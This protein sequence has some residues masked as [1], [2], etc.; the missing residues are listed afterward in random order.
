MNLLC[1]EIVEMSDFHSRLSS[2]FFCLSF[3]SFQQK[4]FPRCR[5]FLCFALETFSF[6]LNSLPLSS[7]LFLFS[8]EKSFI[9]M[10][11]LRIMTKMYFFTICFNLNFTLSRLFKLCCVFPR[12]RWCRV[13]FRW[14]EAYK[15]RSWFFLIFH[16]C[17]GSF[18]N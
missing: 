15:Q 12:K 14:D 13:T 17:Y 1:A 10:M 4:T 16:R 5:H 6:G 8:A 9:L 11:L 3:S 18:T 7:S 2:F